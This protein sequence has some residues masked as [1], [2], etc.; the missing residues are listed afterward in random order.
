MDIFPSSPLPILAVEITTQPGKVAGADK[1]R[2]GG[3]Y[4]PLPQAGRWVRGGENGLGRAEPTRRR[5][6]PSQAP[7][8][9]ALSSASWLFSQLPLLFSPQRH[10]TPSLRL[11]APG[12]R[13]GATRGRRLRWAWRRGWGG[14]LR[15]AAA[16]TWREG[17][18]WSSAVRCGKRVLYA[19]H[20]FIFNLNCCLTV[21]HLI[22]YASYCNNSPAPY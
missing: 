4:A 20:F 9:P 21:L 11:A 8:A 22:S 13:R 3:I 1:S 15:A 19:P 18:S 7:P 17:A 16:I 5:S 14:R 12:A 6:A 10:A 2:F